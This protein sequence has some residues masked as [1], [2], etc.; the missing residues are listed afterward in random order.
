MQEEG[1]VTS[2]DQKKA[3]DEAPGSDDSNTSTELLKKRGLDQFRFEE[4]NPI[5][6]NAMSTF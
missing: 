1:D 4:T 6:S 3:V 5:K 2:K